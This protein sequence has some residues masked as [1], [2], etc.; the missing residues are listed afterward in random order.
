[1]LR[2]IDLTSIYTSASFLGR[3]I[4]IFTSNK[5]ITTS[6]S[7]NVAFP[8]GEV[9]SAMGFTTDIQPNSYQNFLLNEPFFSINVAF[10]S[11]KV[12]SAMGFTTDIQPNSYQ[13]FLLNEST[14][15]TIESDLI[16]FTLLLTVLGFLIA[17][18]TDYRVTYAPPKLP[19]TIKVPDTVLQPILSPKILKTATPA[20][21]LRAVSGLDVEQ[22]ANIFGIS[23]TTYHKWMN[24]SSTPRRRHRE[25]LLEVLSHVEKAAQRLGSRNMVTNW[26]LTPIS[27]VDKKPIEYLA[28]RQYSEFRGFLLQVR[29]GQEVIRPLTPSNRVPRELSDEEI[30]DAL[31]RLRPR[32]RVEEDDQEK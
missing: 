19:N 22:L 17:A 1:M 5:T 11:R 12:V 28:M 32:A 15:E 2:E 10:P 26:L 29:T 13:N 4:G 25:H 20:E 24:G 9:V 14:F 31:E 18:V 30:R 23:R 21:R 27:V 6:S 16:G 8:S 3:S 7:I